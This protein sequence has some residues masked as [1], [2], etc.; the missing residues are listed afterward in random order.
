M[1]SWVIQQIYRATCKSKTVID[2]LKSELEKKKQ[3][4]ANLHEV[5]GWKY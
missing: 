5:R 1:N 2:V 3:K 4:P